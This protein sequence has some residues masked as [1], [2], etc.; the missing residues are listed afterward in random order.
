MML[1]VPELVGKQGSRV[2]MQIFELVLPHD[3]RERSAWKK[4]SCKVAKRMDDP[5]HKGVECIPNAADVMNLLLKDIDGGGPTVLNKG[6]GAFLHQPECHY[7]EVKLARH[8][9]A[10]FGFLHK[11]ILYENWRISS[12]AKAFTSTAADG[13]QRMG[14]QIVHQCL[15]EAFLSAMSE[16]IDRNSNLPIASFFPKQSVPQ[17]VRT[18]THDDHLDIFAYSVT[19]QACAILEVKRENESVA[20]HQAILL[21]FAAYLLT[22]RR[23]ELG[24]SPNLAVNVG[25]VRFRSSERPQCAF[26]VS[27]ETD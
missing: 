24:L 23:T 22:N 18:P 9:V 13:L 27:F 10:N 21:A 25:F 11:E 19:S 12:S 2:E 8:L 3:S 15:G 6:R 16:L 26:R 4:A 7:S 14:S 5:R 1:T 17:K 20:G